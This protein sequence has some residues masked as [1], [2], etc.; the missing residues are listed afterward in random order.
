MTSSH[1]P[2]TGIFGTAVAPSDRWMIPW[3]VSQMSTI[4]LNSTRSTI[5]VVN[6]IV[7]LI[8]RTSHGMQLISFA[9]VSTNEG[10]QVLGRR[11]RPTNGLRPQSCVGAHEGDSSPQGGEGGWNP[12]GAGSTGS[13]CATR[14][15]QCSERDTGLDARAH[16]AHL[17]DA[18]DERF[19]EEPDDDAQDVM[20]ETDPALDPAHRL[21]GIGSTV[22]RGRGQ[23][24]PTGPPAAPR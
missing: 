5:F 19:G 1:R 24:S 6:G 8:V 12:N 15:A 14:W 10:R 4:S 2:S 9:R 20:D 22:G 17:G 3:F 11:G 18:P 13:Y 23:A 7:E 21:R 16:R